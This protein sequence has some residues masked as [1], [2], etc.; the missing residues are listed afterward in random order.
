M[1]YL[2]YA[3]TFLKVINRWENYSKNNKKEFTRYQQGTKLKKT[4]TDKLQE[5]NNKYVEVKIRKLLRE[6]RNK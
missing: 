3:N 6:S 4:T 5:N 1:W 2:D